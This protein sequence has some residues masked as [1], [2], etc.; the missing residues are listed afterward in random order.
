[1]PFRLSN[2]WLERGQQIRAISDH[3]NDIIQKLALAESDLRVQSMIKVRQLANSLGQL[4]L[5]LQHRAERAADLP[6]LMATLGI[7]SMR[8]LTN[9]LTDLNNNSKLSLVTIIQFVLENCVERTLDAIPGEKAQGGFAKGA[10]HLLSV[11]GAKDAKA[12][13]EVL[14]T[15]ARMRNSLHNDGVHN[16][17]DVTVNIGGENFVLTKG[18]RVDCAS[19]SHISW[20]FLHV[21]DIIEEMLLSGVV[22]KIK[23][24]DAAI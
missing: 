9:M 24:I 8:D 23:H 2:T 15:P 6:R 18:Q 4:P 20:V 19:W 14:M 17:A 1:M 7:T 10:R 12:K 11:V 5:M 3:C 16:R 13:Y 22:K 21:L